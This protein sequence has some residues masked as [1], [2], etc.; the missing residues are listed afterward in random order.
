MD[1][2]YLRLFN[3]TIYESLVS[4]ILMFLALFQAYTLYI[5]F[6]TLLVLEKGQF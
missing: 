6:W 4:S 2:P 3:I 5:L 1:Y